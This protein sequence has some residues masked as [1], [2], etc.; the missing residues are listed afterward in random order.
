[1]F[2]GFFSGSFPGSLKVNNSCPVA[3]SHLLRRLSPLLVS[4]RLPLVEGDSV[5]RA[6]MTFEREQFLSGCASHTFAVP[7]ALPVRMRLPS[8]EKATDQ[9]V[10]VCP[11]S[12][13]LQLAGCR[14]P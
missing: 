9:T 13:I 3:A 11:L 2:S 8:G 7:S 14:V 12:V 5:D 10:S 1:M 4:T 6:A